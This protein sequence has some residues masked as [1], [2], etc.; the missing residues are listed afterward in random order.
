[1][2]TNGTL[3]YEIITGGGVNEYGEPV[4]SQSTWCEPIRCSIRA[5][6]DT[7]RGR[8]EDGVFRQASFVVLIERNAHRDIDMIA[9]IKRVRLV[10]GRESLGEYFVLSVVP[11]ESVGR[12]QIDV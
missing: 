9:D 5:N 8:Y 6:T 2:R 1:M 4:A 10:R 3:Q 7:R 12:V 11:A